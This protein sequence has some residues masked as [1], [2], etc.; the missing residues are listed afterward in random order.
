M[1]DQEIRNIDEPFSN[2][3]MFP[4]DPNGSASEVCN[5]RCALLQRATWALGQKDLDKLKER[6]EY[7]KELNE[8]FNKD[9]SFKDFENRLKKIGAI[10]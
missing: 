2:G 5:C 1:V 7:Y 10:K 4:C 3:L 6:A 9:E 8:S